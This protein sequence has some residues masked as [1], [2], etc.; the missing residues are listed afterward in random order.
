[1]EKLLTAKKTKQL[2]YPRLLN[3]L[4]KTQA[5]W[6]IAEEEANV[7]V[8]LLLLR[9]L[10]YTPPLYYYLTKPRDPLPIMTY[11]PLMQ[12]FRELH[13]KELHISG[14]HL[15]V[16]SELA[17]NDSLPFVFKG[18]AVAP[19]QLL[20]C[21]GRFVQQC[22]ICLNSEEIKIQLTRYTYPAHRD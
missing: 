7:E 21:V 18:V 16:S 14:Q 3:H 10:G 19:E 8:T 2:Y 9:R 11:G 4:A 5:S 22:F 15:Q 12:Y 17:T 20:Y 6:T 13:P 1:M